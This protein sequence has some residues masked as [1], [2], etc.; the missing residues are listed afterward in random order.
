MAV[1]TYKNNSFQGWSAVKSIVS[2]LSRAD[3]PQMPFGLI[4]EIHNPFQTNAS[5]VDVSDPSASYST[6]SMNIK[7][8]HPFKKG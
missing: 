3:F 8:C 4:P 6:D 2:G 7:V 1:Y 5:Q